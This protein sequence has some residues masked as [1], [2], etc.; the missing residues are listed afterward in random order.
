[1]EGNFASQRFKTSLFFCLIFVV[2]VVIYCLFGFWIVAIGGGEKAET[3]DCSWTMVPAVPT[4]VLTSPI[5]SSKQRT[6]CHQGQPALGIRKTPAVSPQTIS[7][8]C[9]LL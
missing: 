5:Q 4:T 3:A 2:V 7:S 6:T 1:M 8:C 9:A